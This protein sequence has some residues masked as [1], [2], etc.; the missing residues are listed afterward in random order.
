M[1]G[2]VPSFRFAVLV[3]VSQKTPISHSKNGKRTFRGMKQKSASVGF[4]AIPRATRMFDIA[5]FR[6]TMSWSEQNLSHL[7]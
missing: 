1:W 5:M 3:V 4:L 7:T 2:V 6:Q